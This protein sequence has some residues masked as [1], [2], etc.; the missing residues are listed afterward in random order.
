MIMSNQIAKQKSDVSNDVQT[1]EQFI[2][3]LVEHGYP[4]KSLA[5]VSNVVAG[6]IVGAVG[7]VDHEMEL[8]QGVSY[9]V[10]GVGRLETAVSPGIEFVELPK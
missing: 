4:M 1:V 2:A 7:D 10:I 5:I 9:L 8:A 3:S 6:E